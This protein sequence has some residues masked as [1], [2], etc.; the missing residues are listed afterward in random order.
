[1]GATLNTSSIRR[2]RTYAF[3]IDSPTSADP[4]DTQ[5]GPSWNKSLRSPD[6]SYNLDTSILCTNRQI[7]NEA[8]D[9]FDGEFTFIT[10]THDKCD[11]E[12]YFGDFGHST[13]LRDYGVAVVAEGKQARAFPM[14]DMSIDF[15]AGNEPS[16]RD[17][18]SLAERNVS[19]F[20]LEDLPFA[21]VYLHSKTGRDLVPQNHEIR[22]SISPRIANTPAVMKE[23]GPAAKS[24]LRRCI[25]NVS[26]L[27]GAR[28]VKIE[29]PI[30]AARA[31]DTETTMCRYRLTVT[32]A[33]NMVEAHYDCGDKAR[34][35]DDLESAIAE[36]KEALCVIH[37]S[38][39]DF[40]E[41]NYE[42]IHGGPYDGLLV[43][44]VRDEAEVRLHTLI[45]DCFLQSKQHRLA[46]K[47]VER[48]YSPLNSYNNRSRRR[49]KFPLRLP[50]NSNPVVYAKLLLVAAK[51]SL[52]SNNKGEA[53]RELQEAAKHDPVNQDI[54][55]LLEQCS[56]HLEEKN[57]RRKVTRGQQRASAERKVRA[58]L[59]VGFEVTTTRGD[60]AF[61][62][63]NFTLAREKYKAAYSKIRSLSYP[64]RVNNYY[65]LDQLSKDLHMDVLTKL[66]ITCVEL[67][68]YDAVH[69]WAST[70]DT[71]VPLSS[72]GSK[73]IKS[74]LPTQ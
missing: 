64:I 26:R 24:K 49:Q 41:E 3:T 35:K 55:I 14:I 33:L 67:N 74:R 36:Y 46:R 65:D 1:M 25:D 8:L 34:M 15:D 44:F 31:V 69:F 70:L 48:V 27:R 50:N 39:S 62:G 68:D 19:V 16:I 20:V 7:R 43:G 32:E 23:T 40:W 30:S 38:E 56:A 12:L 11:Q 9:I 71:H 73:S 54:Q 17:D 2:A 57:R 22:I 10:I 29:G 45:A 58:A 66:I 42:T 6:Y 61:R 21:C 13:K 51:I 53:F 5:A 47:Y 4:V 37:L 28:N 52:A 63:A 72:A 60:K 18:G 59:E